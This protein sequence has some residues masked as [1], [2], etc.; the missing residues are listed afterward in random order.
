MARKLSLFW[1]GNEIKLK[2]VLIVYMMHLC[3]YRS[4][5]S[6]NGEEGLQYS[7]VVSHIFYQSYSN[8]LGID[9]FDFCNEI[10]ILMQEYIVYYI[11]S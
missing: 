9:Q 8:S 7:N 5:T 4:G 3:Q 2:H 11:Q 1:Y 6:K 10:E